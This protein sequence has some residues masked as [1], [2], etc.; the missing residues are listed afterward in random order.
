MTKSVRLLAAVVAV[1]LLSACVRMPTGG[2]VVESDAEGRA[3]SPPGIYF[4]P[5]PP[6][7]GQV[8]PSRTAAPR[9]G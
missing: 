5:K 1:L 6:Q 4:D 9:P 2:P 8:R 3:E 7:P